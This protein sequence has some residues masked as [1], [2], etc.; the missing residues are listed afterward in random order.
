Q[1]ASSTGTTWQVTPL[2]GTIP[3]G[4]HFLVQEAVGAGGVTPLPAPDASGSIPMSATNGK[5]ALVTTTTPL[6]GSC[7]T[8]VVDLVGFGS[9]NC[10]ETAPTPALSNT[11]AASRTDLYADADDNAAEFAVGVPAPRNSSTTPAPCAPVGP[12]SPV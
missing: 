11:T 12:I 9:A 7:P 2:S 8:G 3:P 6:T 1:Y 10:F 4:G 5:V